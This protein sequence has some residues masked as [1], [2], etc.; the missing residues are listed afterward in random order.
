MTISELFAFLARNPLPS[1]LLAGITVALIVTELRR[2]GGGFRRLNPAQLTALINRNDAMVVDMRA[3]A[4][5][6]AGHI[7]NARNIPAA[8]LDPEHKQLAQAKQRPVVLVCQSGQSA[9]AAAR[10]LHKAGFDQV[11]VLEGGLA[12]WRQADLPVA[13]GR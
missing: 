1:V 10:R 3:A 9:T 13:K 8:Q 4:D 5:F 11:H 7:P 2:V 12:A 6:K